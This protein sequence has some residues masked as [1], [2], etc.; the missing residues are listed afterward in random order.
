MKNNKDR[1]YLIIIGVLI[2]IILLLRMCCGS[3]EK[4]ITKVK[5]DTV[6]NIIT[7]I[8]SDSAYMPSPVITEYIG[9]P[10]P[11]TV[12]EKVDTSG[13]IANYIRQH[14]YDPVMPDTTK[15][16]LNDYIVSRT[17]KK[18]YPVKYGI[19]IIT[20]VVNQNK[21]FKQDM[22]TNFSIPEKIIT[23]TETVKEK[24]RNQFYF[25][26]ELMGYKQTPINYAGL[27]LLLKTKSDKI[28]KVSVMTNWDANLYVNAG[29]YFKIK[30]HK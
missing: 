20:T 26:G 21:L 10:I 16:I 11:D 15:K 2:L 9:T 5:R 12:F 25:G 17:Y 4:V 14:E 18:S 22:K 30:L 7:V 19:V 8:D 27:G 3:K 24:K 28:Y 6:T 13:I 1:F 29:L 23:K